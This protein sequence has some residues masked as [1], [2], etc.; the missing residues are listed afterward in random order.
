[1]Q[2][3]LVRKVSYLKTVELEAP[4]N[5]FL[6]L[7]GVELVE[8]KVI[9]L[10]ENVMNIRNSS[11]LS[12]FFFTE[13]PWVK[14]RWFDLYDTKIAKIYSVKHILFTSIRLNS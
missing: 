2:N 7:S 9:L 5:G 3:L 14:V 4:L 11:F 12:I 13:T 1:M 6:D 8:Q 10:S